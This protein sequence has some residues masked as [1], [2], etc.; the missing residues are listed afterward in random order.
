M[1]EGFFLAST[2]FLKRSL[3]HFQH[4]SDHGSTASDQGVVFC[5]VHCVLQL[6]FRLVVVFQLLRLTFCTV[7]YEAFV[8]SA[9]Q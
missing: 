4:S 3:N 1:P 2:N 6:Q 7:R 5:I 9:E 8:L